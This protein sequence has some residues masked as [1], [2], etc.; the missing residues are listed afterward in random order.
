[1]INQNQNLNEIQHFKSY[2]KTFQEYYFLKVNYNF[3]LK[4]RHIIKQYKNGRVL[5]HAFHHILF[6]L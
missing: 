3:L 2:I 1:M 5:K 4:G 6:T